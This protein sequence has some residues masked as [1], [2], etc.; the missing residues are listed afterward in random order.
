MFILRRSVNKDVRNQIFS[1]PKKNQAPPSW[2]RGV[3][4]STCTL[5]SF[6][7]G[8]NDG[9]KGIGLMMLILIGVLPSYFAITSAKKLKEI[10]PDLV[11]IETIVSKIDTVGLGVSEMKHI[12]EIKSNVAYLMPVVNQTS[13]DTLGKLE[14]RG[15]ILKVSSNTKKL[16]SDESVKLSKEDRESLSK[17][18]VK[19]E[20]GIRKAT[21]VAPFWVILLISISLGLGTM[22]GWKRIVVTVGEDF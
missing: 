8:K 20:K 9:Q 4:I 14:L 16:L 12:N 10:E 15:A 21:D 17:A 18:A 7:H 22:I 1:E 11:K 19:E 3:L 2:I 6:F 13:N 5:V